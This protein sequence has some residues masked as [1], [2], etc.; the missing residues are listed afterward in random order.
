MQAGYTNKLLAPFALAIA[1][2]PW[3]LAAIANDTNDARFT[4]RKEEGWF[5]YNETYEE[6]P[7][8][9]EPPPPEPPPTVTVVEPPKPQEMAPA[10]SEPPPPL[11][12][13]WMR[14]NLPKY[15]DRAWNDPSPENVQAFFTL[16]RYAM[17]RSGEFAEVAQKVT[18]GNAMLD[19]SS[20]RPFST[21]A[22]QDLDR[23]AGQQR[24]ALLDKIASTAGLFVIYSSECRLCQ[25]MAPVLAHLNG[26]FEMTPISMDGKDLPGAPFPRMR[27]D[28]GHAEQLGVQALP[29]I[30]LVSQEAEFIP[31]AQ[32]A[33][34]LTE[35]RERIVLGAMQMGLVTQ[36]EYNRTRTVNNLHL[37]LAK[38]PINLESNPDDPTGFIDPAVLIQSLQIP[39]P[40]SLS[41]E[42]R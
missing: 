24:T 13:E 23:F 32:G 14:E 41:P 10:P 29:A 33:T 15:M 16:Q 38:Q 27:P 3:A 18:M 19:E 39:A 7:E 8:K 2:G 36:E 40:S 25:T 21:F 1:L 28:Q 17:D 4:E 30:Y 42:R 37:N 9:V 35:L 5:F 11:S 22:A 31:L 26:Q 12:A 6:E 20:R 34:S